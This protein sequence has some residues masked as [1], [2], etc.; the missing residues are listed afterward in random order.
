MK[1][2]NEE[3]I[4]HRSSPPTQARFPKEKKKTKTMKKE[5]RIKNEIE[6]G[7][8]KAKIASRSNDKFTDRHKDRQ[9]DKPTDSHQNSLTDNHIV[10]KHLEGLNY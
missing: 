2:N 3:N 8:W 1:T 10:K 4:E 9:I 7:K 5:I 6:W